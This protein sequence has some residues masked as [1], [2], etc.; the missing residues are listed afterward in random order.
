MTAMQRS[1]SSAAGSR[2]NGS[3]HKADIGGLW[4]QPSRTQ[5]SSR[6]P[7]LPPT[8]LG[9]MGASIRLIAS[10]QLGFETLETRQRDGLDFRSCSVWCVRAALL[11]AG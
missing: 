9:Q 7:G 2:L 6:G 8:A 5:S 11:E 3:K 1:P 10:G 4:A